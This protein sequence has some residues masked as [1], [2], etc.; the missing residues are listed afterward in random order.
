MF[1]ET[2]FGIQ[3]LG[4]NIR[5]SNVWSDGIRNSN[6]SSDECLERRHSEFKC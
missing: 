4:V 2:T 3:M 5:Y 6:V 1:G